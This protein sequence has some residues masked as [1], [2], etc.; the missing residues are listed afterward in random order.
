MTNICSSQAFWIIQSSKFWKTQAHIMLR[1]YLRCAMTVKQ[2]FNW[3]RLS[4]IWVAFKF[5][6]AFRN[7]KLN[8]QPQ[9]VFHTWRFCKR[10]MEHREVNQGIWSQEE[11]RDNR[12]NDVQFS[13]KT[14]TKQAVIKHIIQW[15]CTFWSQFCYNQ[16]YVI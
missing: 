5:V 13:C 12:C 8:S 10:S 6:S 7:W 14:R 3:T 15:L 9:N 2:T 16:F 4:I 1:L 11:I